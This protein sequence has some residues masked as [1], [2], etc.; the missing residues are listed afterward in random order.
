MDRLRGKTNR[1]AS[2][3]KSWALSQMNSQRGG[4]VVGGGVENRRRGRGEGGEKEE[5]GGGKERGE[6]ERREE[7]RGREVLA[8]LP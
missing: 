4:R 5:G 2:A 6:G 1:R 8:P 3:R 7:G